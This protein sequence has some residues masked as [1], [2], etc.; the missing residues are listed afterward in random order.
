MVSDRQTDRPTDIAT[1]R[2]A[3]V[4]NKYLNEKIEKNHA[5]I[6]VTITCPS[7]QKA[8][9]EPVVCLSRGILLSV[10][11]NIKSTFCAKPDKSEAEVKKHMHGCHSALSQGWKLLRH[12]GTLCPVG[13]RAISRILVIAPTLLLQI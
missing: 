8:W 11:N 7:T 12:M 9:T 1:Y 10:I 4:A 13:L 2:A 3:I 6:Q 5:Y